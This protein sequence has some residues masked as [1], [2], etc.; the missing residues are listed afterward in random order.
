M[1]TRTLFRRY[2]T[3]QSF[4]ERCYLTNSPQRTSLLSEVCLSTVWK[5]QVQFKYMPRA[6]VRYNHKEPD[7]IENNSIFKKFRKTFRDYWYVLVPVHFVSTAGW[8]SLFYYLVKSGLDVPEFLD[9]LGLTTSAQ[10]FRDSKM[11]N[12]A[13]ALA[14]LKLTSPLRY[15]LTVAIT[16]FSINF[17]KKRGYVKPIP[18]KEEI[19]EIYEKKKSQ[20]KTRYKEKDIIRTCKTKIKR[21]RDKMKERMKS[22]FKRK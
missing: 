13:I 11:G 19:K 9:K 7:K 3:L 4:F 20:M 14:L 10:C 8:A 18:S 21:R 16:T 1:F 22:K 17:L 5:N 2:L 6:C 12:L 15:P